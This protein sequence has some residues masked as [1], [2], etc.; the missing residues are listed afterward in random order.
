MSSDQPQCDYT[1]GQTTEICVYVTQ[2]GSPRTRQRIR[3][4]SLQFIIVN[5]KHNKTVL[6]NEIKATITGKKN[7]YI[8]K[9]P[10]LIK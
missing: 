9:I 8:F 10:E 6:L 4:A 5:R 3:Q 1:D 2:V 7:I